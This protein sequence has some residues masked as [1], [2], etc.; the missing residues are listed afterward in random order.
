MNKFKFYISHLNYVINTEK[1]IITF[2]LILSLNI[3]GIFSMDRNQG[4]FD[5]LYAINTSSIINIFLLLACI[6]N[7]FTIYDYVGNNKFYIIRCENKNE[8]N[9]AIIRNVI[10][11]NSII[12]MAGIGIDIIGLLIKYKGN[13]TIGNY[14]FYNIS[15]IIYFCFFLFRKI[16]Y[17][18]L[19][20]VIFIYINKLLGKIIMNVSLFIL[21]VNMITHF[22]KYDTVIAS[23]SNIRL[24]IG[25][26][27]GVFQYISFSLEL[28]CSLFMGIILTIIAFILYK[29]ILKFCQ[30]VI[31]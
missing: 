26:Y 23:F 17:I 7:T 1:F 29:L 21:I 30:Q 27:F 16:V 2:I 6:L 14:Y 13:Y 28:A 8:H 15:N 4:I 11:L 5:G 25:Y 18:N 31:F 24:F 22:Y 19:L 3:Y 9:N 20:A 12:I 10:L